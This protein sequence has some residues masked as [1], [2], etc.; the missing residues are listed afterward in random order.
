MAP[1]GL[2][3]SCPLSSESRMLRT[4]QYGTPNFRAAPW[5]YWSISRDPDGLK[6]LARRTAGGNAGLGVTRFSKVP[7]EGFTMAVVPIMMSVVPAAIKVWRR[8]GAQAHPR[9]S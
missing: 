7:A 1:W 2:T 5:A 8:V 6:V 3:D 9:R 4:A